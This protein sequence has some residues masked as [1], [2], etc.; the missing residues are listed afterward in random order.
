MMTRPRHDQ[1]V[2]T[3]TNSPTRRLINRISSP[4][5]STSPPRVTAFK[6]LVVNAAKGMQGKWEWKPKCPILDHGNPQYALKDNGVIDSGCSRNMIGN[7]SYLSD[8]EELNGRYVTFGGNPKGG[9]IS[10]KGLPTKVFENDNTCVACKKGKQHRASC[11]TK[12]VSSVDQPLYRLHMDLFGPTFV[13]SLN[14]KSYCLVI[15]DDYSRAM[16]ERPDIHAQIWKNQRSVHG[17]AKVKSWKLLE[18]CGVQIITFTTSQLILLVEWRYPLI[19]FRVDAAMDFKEKHA[20]CL[21]LLV[22]D[23]VL[24]SQDDDL[25]VQYFHYHAALATTVSLNQTLMVDLSATIGAPTVVIG[26]EAG[27]EPNSGRLTKYTA[28]ISV[29]KPDSSAFVILGDK[30]DIYTIWM[31]PKSALM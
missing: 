24:P 17:Q 10:R 22:K 5:S 31:N 16:F 11:K 19:S 18:S 8:F 20:K 9:K 7:M 30:G 26:A 4:K 25:K 29:N 6:A 2:V 15:T 23:L 12:L 21:M 1:L 27:Y 28:S 14:K 13:K 3:K